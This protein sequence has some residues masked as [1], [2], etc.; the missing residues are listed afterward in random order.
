MLTC[1][2]DVV[3]YALI[4]SMYLCVYFHAIW[5]DHCLHMVICLDPCS[6]MS[7][8]Q[9]STCLHTCFYAYMSR[10]MLSHANVLGSM[11]STCFMLSSMCFCAS[12]YVCHAMCYCSPFVAFSFF[13]VFWPNG[14]DPIQNIWSLS[15]SIQQGP[16]KRV[17]IT[18]ICMSTLAC[19][20]ALCLC[21]PL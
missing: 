21:W 12:C 7:M 6:S 4:G 10:S 5:L 15:S 1:L 11:S 9:A 2:Y 16:H 13:I 14:Q 3:G 19:F 8:C 17:W 20:Y 18:P